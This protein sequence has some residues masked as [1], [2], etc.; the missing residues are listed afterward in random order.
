MHALK[1]G[2]TKDKFATFWILLIRFANDPYILCKP[3]NAS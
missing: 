2:L 1:T 3:L